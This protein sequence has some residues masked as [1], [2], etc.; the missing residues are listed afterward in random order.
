M[1]STLW[2]G[3]TS[4]QLY[5]PTRAH[6]S[7]RLVLAS[8]WQGDTLP[9][10]EPVG[11]LQVS[12][13]KIPVIAPLNGISVQEVLR[14]QREGHRCYVAWLHSVPVAYGWSATRGAAI[15]E[16]GCRLTLG[17]HDRYLWDFATAAAWRGRG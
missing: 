12:R 9:I 4:T 5:P 17:A 14:R 10:L 8:W 13:A 6:N 3:H 11:S 7:A 16:I 2:T 15:G 1:T